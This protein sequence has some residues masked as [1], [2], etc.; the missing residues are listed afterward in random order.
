MSDT[1]CGCGEQKT[2]DEIRQGILAALAVLDQIAPGKPIHGYM[3]EDYGWVVEL[4]DQDYDGIL[5][6]FPDSLVDAEAGTEPLH[7]YVHNGG[8]EYQ[9]MFIVDVEGA[10]VERMV[11]IVTSDNERFTAHFQRYLDSSPVERTCKAMI[12]DWYDN[13]GQY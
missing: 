13:Y 12:K 3:D 10:K 9:D 1:W 5:A 11:T 6:R 2:P 4:S 7:T 8:S